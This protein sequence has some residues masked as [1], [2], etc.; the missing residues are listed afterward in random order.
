MTSARL[1][2]CLKRTHVCVFFDSF[3][4]CFFVA[5]RRILQQKYLKGQIIGTC[6]PGKCCYSFWPCTQ[7]LRATNHNA[8]CYRQMDG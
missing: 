3:F 7:T 8:Q 6:L 5:K 1:I 4:R 2:V